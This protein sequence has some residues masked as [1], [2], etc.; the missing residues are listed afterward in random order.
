MKFTIRHLSGSRAGQEQVLDGPVIRL[1]RDPSSQVAFD[2]VTDDRVSTNHAQ[3]LL[4]GD[5]QVMLSDLGSRNGTFLGEQAVK[6]MVPLMSGAVVCLG[7]EGGPQVSV[8]FSADTAAVPAVAP[9]A[10]APPPAKSGGGKTCLLCGVLALV[11]VGCPGAVAGLYLL[12]RGDGSEPVA[13]DVPPPDVPPPADGVA[14]VDPPKPAEPEQAPAPA[15]P[16]DRRTAWGKL[17][18]GSVFEQRS[19]TDMKVGEQSMTTESVITYTVKAVGEDEVTV[20]MKTALPSMPDF[21]PTANDVQFPA[22]VKEGEAGEQPEVLEEKKTD[23]TVPAGTFPCTYR[24]TRAKVG[25]AETTTELWYDEAEAL[26]YKVTVVNAQ[27][28]SVT[29]LT[30]RE[31]K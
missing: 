31:P 15:E 7:G 16:V 10:P 4:M 22:R 17:G 5:G 18:V 28:S 14:A 20:E 8:T 9:A 29:E 3:L 12:T 19:K 26:P 11:L 1:G 27:M 24:K 23:V 2:P 13:V 6:G 21:P 25:D 30:R